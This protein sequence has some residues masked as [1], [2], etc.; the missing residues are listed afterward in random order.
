MWPFRKKNVVVAGRLTIDEAYGDPAA[1]A[2]IDALA[3]RDWHT[4]RDVVAAATEPDAR[5]YLLEA[6]A[7]VDGV[8]DWIG[9]WV[10]AEPDSTL[11]VL[12]KGT[13]AVFWAWEARGGASSDRTSQEKFREFHRRLR[14]AEH[15]LADVAA[16]D[17]D[18]VT[19]RTWLVTSARGTQMG[20]EVAQARF[21]EVVKRH[22]FHV[23]AHEQRLQYLCDKW[24]GSHEEMFAFAR[25][26]AASAPDGSLLP[27]LIPV[28]HLEKWLSLPSG[29]DAVYITSQEVRDEVIAAAERSVLHPSFTPAHGWVPRANSFAMAL[30]MTQ[31]IDH[32]ARVFDLLGDR[33]SRWPWFYHGKD[34]AEA[35]V[36]GR[37]YVYENRTPAS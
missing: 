22:P 18:D 37:D 32:A 5:A 1:R 23:V 20:K 12:V 25:S 7:G 17:P 34:P 35:F 10:R 16:R 19:A 3:G 8:Q 33:V 31:A 26:A 2:L 11:P 27:E 36:T 30:E 21:D 14:I 4:A 29:D 9:D 15:L 13:H 28:A 24:F 6:A